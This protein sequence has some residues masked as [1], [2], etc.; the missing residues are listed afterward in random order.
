MNYWALFHCFLRFLWQK[1]QWRHSFFAFLLGCRKSC[2]YLLVSVIRPVLHW[3][4]VCAYVARYSGSGLENCFSH[5][6]KGINDLNHFR[7]FHLILYVPLW[8]LYIVVRWNLAWLSYEGTWLSLGS[9]SDQ[10][11]WLAWL[12]SLST[13]ARKNVCAGLNSAHLV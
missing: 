7:K 9:P 8:I 5:E 6:S 1:K 2:K 10:S 3:C 13:P 4:L 11:E 12:S